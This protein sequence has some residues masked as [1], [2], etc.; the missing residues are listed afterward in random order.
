MESAAALAN[1]L[2]SL[3]TYVLIVFVVFGFLWIQNKQIA[4]Q[5]DATERSLRAVEEAN[6]THQTMQ[7]VLQQMVMM[8]TKRTETITLTA[9]SV[10]AQ[11]KATDALST[12][13]ATTLPALVSGSATQTSALDTV[14]GGQM[15][16]GASVK[17]T[18]DAV[19]QILALMITNGVTMT[20]LKKQM[21]EIN[22]DV[23]TLAE[24]EIAPT[25]ATH[26]AV[27]EIT[28]RGEGTPVKTAT[29]TAP[30]V[31]AAVAGALEVTLPVTLVAAAE[32][33]V[34]V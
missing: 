3:P 20:G 22:G 1:L 30:A 14:S 34:P 26:D 32:T 12:T 33:A 21:S 17:S 9:A 5:R 16:I 28:T 23:N 4:I 6:R 10:A 7:Q 27:R 19:K 11:T 25:Q 29:Q 15:V 2:A 24:N 31:P 13:L 18:S 8:D